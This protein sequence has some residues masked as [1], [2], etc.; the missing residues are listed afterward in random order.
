MLSIPNATGSCRRGPRLCS[1]EEIEA[2]WATFIETDA[3]S[4]GRWQG[5]SDAARED[6]NNMFDRSL[7][8]LMGQHGH[9]LSRAYVRDHK[10]PQRPWLDNPWHRSQIEQTQLRR[11]KPTD[12]SSVMEYVQW[13]LRV[14]AVKSQSASSMADGT[15]STAQQA[16]QRMRRLRETRHYIHWVVQKEEYRQQQEQQEQ[17]QQQQQQQQHTPAS[18][19]TLDPS[20]T[21]AESLAR[22]V[23]CKGSSA[24]ARLTMLPAFQTSFKP[25]LEVEGDGALKS[26]MALLKATKAGKVWPGLRECGLVGEGNIT[27][28]ASVVECVRDELLR[29]KASSDGAWADVMHRLAGGV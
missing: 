3:A 22:D 4:W 25:V 29:R 15:I 27:S 16:Y 12:A 19:A 17:Q 9:L 8:E 6:V 2:D 14:L 11:H 7:D 5:L 13:K 28:D 21:F 24:P 18:S 26:F 10:D 1:S 23:I 20:F